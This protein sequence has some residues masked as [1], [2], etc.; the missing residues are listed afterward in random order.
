MRS[1]LVAARL[2][3]AAGYLVVVW[4][5]AHAD[6]IDRRTVVVA[7]VRYHRLYAG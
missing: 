6:R 4:A 1:H 5:T 3:A 7:L 2:A